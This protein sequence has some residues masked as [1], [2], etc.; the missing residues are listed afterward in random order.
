MHAVG[1]VVA[2]PLQCDTAPMHTGAAVVKVKFRVTPCSMFTV[3]QLPVSTV[4]CRVVEG[5]GRG[6]LHPILHCLVHSLR[7]MYRHATFIYGGKKV[8]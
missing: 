4:R 1:L 7:R 8:S 5:R 2:A 6:V 3:Q